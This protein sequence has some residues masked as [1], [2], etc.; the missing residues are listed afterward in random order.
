MLKESILNFDNYKAKLLQILRTSN[1]FTFICSS[2]NYS[3]TIEDL[4]IVDEFIKPIF[5][6][7]QVCITGF[8]TILWPLRVY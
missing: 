6:V 5:F 2:G 8:P 3:A 4:L 1:L 7:G